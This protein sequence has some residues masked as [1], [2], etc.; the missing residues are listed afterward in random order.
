M[1]DNRG[2]PLPETERMILS[3]LLNDS[4]A[5]LRVMEFLDD[6]AQFSVG[7]YGMVYQTIMALTKELIV[8]NVYTVASRLSWDIEALQEIAA[9]FN[10]KTSKEVLYLA[11]IVAREA[12]WRSVQAALDDAREMAA[13]KP[14]DIEGFAFTAMQMISTTTEGTNTRDPSVLEVG[15]ALDAEIA[16]IENGALG[17]PTGLTWLDAK[18]GGIAKGTVWVLS[19]PYK[20]RK[21]TVAR[22]MTLAMLKAGASVDWYALEGNRTGTLA[23]LLAML[24]TEKLR[25]WGKLDEMVLSETY[26]MRGMRSGAKQ[27]AISDARRELDGY[28]L[29]IYDGKDGVHSPEKLV[30]KIKRSSMLFGLNAFVVDY[31]QLLGQGKLFERMEAAAH[32]LPQTIQQ[33]GIAGILLTQLNEA[34]IWSQNDDANEDANYSP[35]VKG[36]GDIPA[37]ADYLLTTR[38]RSAEPELIKIRLKLARHAQPGWASYEINPESGLIGREKE[39]GN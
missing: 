17:L 38:Y 32:I 37:A 25:A 18:T 15:R 30:S 23:G 34:T 7:S 33:T 27:D 3:V 35:G 10:T 24:A 20:G 5:I 1:P 16:D 21:T 26:I 6:P 29:R 14:E 9:G 31:V 8:P 28:N 36:G 12:K 19:A 39:T 2:T 22:H 13:D 4:H 11:E